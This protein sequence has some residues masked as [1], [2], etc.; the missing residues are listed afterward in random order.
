MHGERSTLAVCRG[1]VSPDLSLAARYGVVQLRLGFLLRSARH[2]YSRPPRDEP[3]PARAARL[4]LTP[5]SQV[6]PDPRLTFRNA[7]SYSLFLLLEGGACDE[8][9]SACQFSFH[10]V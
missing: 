3:A 5:C 6:G 2:I 7:I 4:E 1:V 8:V 9:D 10:V